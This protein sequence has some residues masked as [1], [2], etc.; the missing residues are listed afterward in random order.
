MLK[1]NLLLIVFIFPATANAQTTTQE[2]A[3]VQ[4]T[5]ENLFSALTNADT[6]AMKSFTTR[7]VRFYEY[8]E[9]WTMDTLIHKVIQSKS[10]PDFKRTNKF[11]FVSTTIKKETAWV[12]YYLQSTITRNGKE[13]I[14]KWMETVVLIKEKKQWKIEVLHSTRLPKK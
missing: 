10:I 8:G 11:E 7:N 2:Q 9:I 14:V 12:T 5:I 1:L 4:R 13:E 3:T 6:L